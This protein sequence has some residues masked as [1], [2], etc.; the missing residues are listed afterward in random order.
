MYKMFLLAPGSFIGKLVDNI[1]A[2]LV[3]LAGLFSSSTD[4]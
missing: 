2:S 1:F 3:M 4:L